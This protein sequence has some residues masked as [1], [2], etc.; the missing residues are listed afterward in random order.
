MR[1][2]VIG[3]QGQIARSLREVASRSGNIA[4]GFGARPDVDLSRPASIAKALA[5]FRPDLVVNPAAYTAVD[6]A[7]SEPDQA[8]AVNRDGARAVASAAADRGVP[9]IHL[10][11]DYVFDGKKKGPYSETDPVSPQGVYGRSK[12]EGE[13]AVAEANPKHIVLRTSWVYAPFGS[14]FVR[15]MLRL[16]AERDRLQVVDD[17]SGCPTY[18]PDIAE[19]IIAIARKWAGSDWH[20]KYAGVT[21]MAGPDVRTWCGFARE[22]VQRAG[23]RGGRL[24]PVDPISTSDYP[25]PATRPANSCLSS[26]RLQAVFGL[27]LPP[28]TSSLDDCLDRLLCH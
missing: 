6:K 17:Q 20:S 3:G 7:E 13:L 1:L 4:F 2:F 19:A 16:T 12:L 26:E 9:V 23:E 24:I 22:I 25:T 11:T 15:T 8:F 27:R 21:H 18:A 14:N 5:D 28:L 10:S